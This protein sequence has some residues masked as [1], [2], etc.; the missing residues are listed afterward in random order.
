MAFLGWLHTGV[1]RKMQIKLYLT[2]LKDL[3]WF[4]PMYSHGNNQDMSCKPYVPPNHHK[5]EFHALPPW[6]LPLCYYLTLLYPQQSQDYNR[7]LNKG[8]WT[9]KQRAPSRESCSFWPQLIQSFKKNLGIAL[10]HFKQQLATRRNTLNIHSGFESRKSELNFTENNNL[11][12]R[13]NPPQ[14]WHFRWVETSVASVKKRWQ[15]LLVLIALVSRAKVM[16]CH[17]FYGSICEYA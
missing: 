14:W 16:D 11:L 3:L 17:M 8:K 5:H 6:E 9:Q 1:T 2:V 4:V 7:A 10:P 12:T 13:K 15:E